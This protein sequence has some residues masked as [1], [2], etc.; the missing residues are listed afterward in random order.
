[1]LQPDAFG[2]PMSP[3]SAQLAS[4]G[5]MPTHNGFTV[6]FGYDYGSG[7]GSNTTFYN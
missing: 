6:P 5:Y 1:M 2:L 3:V 4:F 7:C